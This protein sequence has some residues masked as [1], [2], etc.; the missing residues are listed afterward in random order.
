MIGNVETLNPGEPATASSSIDVEQD[1]VYFN[2]GIPQGVKGDTGDIN[3]INFEVENG[4]LKAYDE[5]GHIYYL[6][7]VA[8][9]PKGEYSATTSYEKLNTVLYNDSTYMALKSSLGNPPTDTEYWQLI[10]GGVRREDIVDNLDSNDNT[11]MLSAK[12]GKILNE[13]KVQVFDTVADMK[14]A[15]LK[16]GMT[17]QTLGYYDINDGG[18]GEYIIVDDDTLVEDGGS[19]HVLTNGL[20]AELINNIINPEMYGAI[21]D[22]ETNDHNALEKCF[23]SGKNVIINK[24]YYNGSN[25]SIN[26]DL[27][28]NGNNAII[29]GYGIETNKKVNIENIIFKDI[30]YNAISVTAGELNVNNCIFDNIGIAEDLVPNNQGAG[31]FSTNTTTETIINVSNSIFKNCYSHGAI[32]TTANH[33]INIR[34]NKFLDNFYRAI[35]LYG[36]HGSYIQR[37]IIEN[38]LINGCGTINT[39]NSGVGCNGIYSTC[40]DNVDIVN[41]NITNCYEN[42]I[43]GRFKSIIGNNISYTNNDMTNH[44]TPSIEGIYLTNNCNFIVKNN[45]LNHVKGRGI[46]N[47]S[48]ETNESIYIIEDNIINVDS[49]NDNKYSIYFST[50]NGSFKNKKILNNITNDEIFIQ[51]PDETCVYSGEISKI[52]SSAAIGKMRIISDYNYKYRYSKLFND[53]DEFT[54]SNCTPTVSTDSSI[55]NK[56]VSYSYQQYNRLIPPQIPYLTKGQ[57][58]VKTYA[59]GKFKI[60]VMKNGSY[61][62]TLFNI[63]NNSYELKEGTIGITANQTDVITLWICALS[64]GTVNMQSMYCEV[65]YL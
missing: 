21:G 65:T 62:T 44:P 58:K 11:K 1:I 49:Y 28:I 37:G 52:S 63:D 43:E 47:T 24:N 54:Y 9:E 38:N 41:N 10:G 35:H 40:A 27:L 20:R 6:G 17:V 19:I 61:Y 64:G 18:N 25:I 29:S 13:G 4:V 32:F 16:E 51:N 42:A 34:N 15:D 56:V 8:M 7:T 33:F 50:S 22:G 30:L 12:Q 31:I 39:T 14:T 36:N 55:N 3:L 2:F 53:L 5:E 26:K 57:I 48:E 23:N 45:V 59:K 60:D 46:S